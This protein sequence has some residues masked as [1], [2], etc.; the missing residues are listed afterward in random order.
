MDDPRIPRGISIRAI[1]PD[2]VVPLER[3]YAGLSRDSLD[4]RFHGGARGIED[5]A[6][7]TFCGPDHVHR[8]GL[9]A[10][11]AHRHRDLIVGHLCLEPI[12]GEDVEMAVAVADAW[13]HHGIGRALLSAA[14]EWAR[15]H[16][17]RRVHGTIRWSNPAILGLVR[18]CGR[19]VRI[20]TTAEGD[21]E[22]VIDI[23]RD[24]PAAA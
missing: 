7:K 18:A 14:L 22:A 2:D 13:Q 5:R 16:G 10:V 17:F 24:L 3:F 15:V 19:A 23:V 20:V 6:A 1:R 8:E 9:V 21:T 12:G 11:V 4:A